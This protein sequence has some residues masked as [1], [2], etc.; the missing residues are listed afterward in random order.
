VTGDEKMKRLIVPTPPMGD[1]RGL[2]AARAARRRLLAASLAGVALAGLPRRAWAEE[3][4]P[5][6]RQTAGPF[7]PVEFPADADNDLVAVKGARGT[8]KGELLLLAGTV[9]D[10]TGRPLSGARVEIWQCNAFGRYLHPG[11][12]NPAPLDPNFQGYGTFA[13][14]ADGAYSFRTIKPVPYPGRTPHIHFRVAGPGFAPLVTQMYI[15]GEPGNARDGLFNSIRDERARR[16]VTVE[17]AQARGGD[18][19]AGRFDLVLRAS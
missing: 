15:A 14:A 13:T 8:A 18:A 4:I 16:S 11:D 5:T 9:M 17:L 2:A 10:L 12:N 1:A 19:L 3:R 6:P 7:Y